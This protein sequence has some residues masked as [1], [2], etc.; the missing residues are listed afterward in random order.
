MVTLRYSLP[1]FGMAVYRA[2][3]S[4]LCAGNLLQVCVRLEDVKK[5]HWSSVYTMAS[6]I[7][8]INFLL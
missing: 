4:E 3:A 7:V 2:S 1:V 5:I 6:T 8:G